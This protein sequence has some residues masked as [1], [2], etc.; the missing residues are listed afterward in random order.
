MGKYKTAVNYPTESSGPRMEV[1]RDN[2]ATGAKF[3]MKDIDDKEARKK[4]EDYAN[5]MQRETRGKKK[6]GTVKSAS[7][8][9]DG[10]AMRG[11]TRGKMV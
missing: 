10:C 3:P 8:R 7:A 4:A 9:A 5:E 1:L 6:G 2:M 11:K